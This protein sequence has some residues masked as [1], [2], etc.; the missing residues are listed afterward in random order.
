VAAILGAKMEVYAMEILACALYN[1]QA[2]SAKK[3]VE[4]DY[5]SK[6]INWTFAAF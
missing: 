5:H 2:Y 4:I 1:I 3:E 6:R